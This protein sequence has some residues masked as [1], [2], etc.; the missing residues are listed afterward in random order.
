MSAALT[1]GRAAFVSAGF[2]S[3]LAAATRFR[4]ATA[5]ATGRDAGSESEERRAGGGDDD[6][7]T[8]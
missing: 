5:P 1:A 3:A 6:E 4:A 2:R 8:Q 7:V